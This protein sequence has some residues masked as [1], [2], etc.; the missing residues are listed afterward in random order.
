MS[1][2]KKIAVYDDECMD[3]ENQ[4]KI[5]YILIEAGTTRLQLLLNELSE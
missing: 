4:Y 2:N 1:S 5:N 3:K